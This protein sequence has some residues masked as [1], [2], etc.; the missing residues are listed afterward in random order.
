MKIATPAMED[1]RTISF[2]VDNYTDRQRLLRADEVD[3]VDKV[4]E[5]ARHEERSAITPTVLAKE[6]CK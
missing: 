4:F 3:E 5:Q 6:G 1:Q 2:L